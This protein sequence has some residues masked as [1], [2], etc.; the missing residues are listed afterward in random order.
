MGDW[1]QD[2][3]NTPKPGAGQTM[4][5]GSWTNDDAIREQMSQRNDPNQ[6]NWTPMS[7][8]DIKGPNGQPM[9]PGDVLGQVEEKL[10]GGRQTDPF[11]LD[12]NA[13]QT[14]DPSLSGSANGDQS[15]AMQ[16]ALM[17]QLQ[18]QAAGKGPSLAQLQLQKGGDQAM[19]QAMALGASQRGA[20]QAGALKGI[21]DQQA[22]IGQ[23]MANDAAILRL[24]EQM[25]ARNSLGTGLSQMRGQDQ[26]QS[27][28]DAGQRNTMAM[29][30]ASNA[31]KA[32]QM[33][34][35]RWKAQQELQAQ[36][37]HRNSWGSVIGSAASMIAGS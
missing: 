25:Q 10:F 27:Q 8:I 5:N 16:L 33:A 13:G 18:D 29:A 6:A 11:N 14:R 37:A 36:A 24:Q 22:K 31:Q 2:F 20:G 28:F 30:N 1:F 26:S 21:A 4:H 17:Q 7:N 15:R 23:G 3:L 34:M 9:Q 35:D 12:M 32:Q 19:S